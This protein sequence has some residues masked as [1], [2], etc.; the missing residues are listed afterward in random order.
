M[1]T[2][3][4]NTANQLIFLIG[5][6]GCGKSTLGKKLAAKV[7]Y[8]F[9]DLDEYIVQQIK[10]SI[11]EYF[12]KHGEIAFRTVEQEALYTLKDANQ[13]IIATGGGAPCHF[14]NMGWMNTHGT[15]V[16][17]KMSPKALLSRLSQNEVET[18]PLLKGK[19]REELLVFIEE[20]LGERDP[21]YN[22]ASIIYDPL[23]EKP[24]D[25]IHQITKTQGIE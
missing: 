25:L 17:I 16:Y 7:G 4:Q 21:I 14:D 15:T 2:T 9:I 24:K 12:E 22:L 6:M 13:T 8:D 19:S 20:K 11:S 23:Q 3:S 5:F 18:R 1:N 10:M